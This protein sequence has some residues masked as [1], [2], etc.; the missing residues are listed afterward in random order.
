MKNYADNI[1]QGALMCQVCFNQYRGKNNPPAKA[2]HTVAGG[3]CSVCTDPSCY[4]VVF[5][6]GGHWQ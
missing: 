4:R 2:L 1:V 5:F 6:L 3:E